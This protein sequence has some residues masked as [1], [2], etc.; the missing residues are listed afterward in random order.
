MCWPLRV[1]GTVLKAPT[2]GNVSS[3]EEVALVCLR[4]CLMLRPT[5]LG[6]RE[7]MLRGPAKAFDC[8]LLPF[9]LN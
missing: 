7:I 5:V 3:R 2:K 1:Y 9:F 8:P 4:K 6:R